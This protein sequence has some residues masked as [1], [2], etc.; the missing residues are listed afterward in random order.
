MPDPSSSEILPLPRQLGR[1]TLV[2]RL[3]Q[4]GMGVVYLARD[5]RLGRDVALKMIAGLT[6]DAAVKR[7]WREARVAASV[8]HPHVCQIFEVDET[9]SGLHIAME[10]LDGESLET[11]LERG[12]LKPRDAVRVATEVLGALGALHER[13]LVHRDVKPSNIFLTTHG[14][15]LLD[16]GLARPAL[17]DTVRLDAK[18]PTEVTQAGMILG[19]PRYMAPEQVSGET[20]DGR[21]DQYSL[22][23]VLFETL[24]GRPPFVGS[25]VFDLLYATLHERPPALQGPPAV[26][27]ID[28]V[29]RRSLEKDPA[30]RFATCE[31]MAVEL[32]AISLGESG[33][34]VASPVRALVRIIVPP[35]RML[36]ADP[37]ITFL[38]FGL[39]DAI[40]G[41]LAGLD[42]VVVRAT[43]VA[44][45]WAEEQPDPR[46]IAAE[47]DVDLVLLGS[48]LRV[49]EQMRA[50][51]QLVE[52]PS[53]TVVGST[54]VK[55]RLSDVF[56][57]EEE[58]TR[59][60]MVL[61]APRRSG[62]TSAPRRDVPATA[63]ALELY[64]RAME[65]S[66]SRD[67]LPEAR[68]L[69]EQV[70]QEDPA[71]APAWAN[72]GR[73]YRVIGKFNDGRDT[74][75][76]PAEEAFRRALALSPNLPVAH[77]FLTHF[78]AE[79]GRA[80][81]AIARLLEHA[82]ANRN[83]AN[84]FAG[85]VHACRYAGL[86]DASLAAHAEARR[87]DPTVATSLE[88][89]LLVLGEYEKFDELSL[90]TGPGDSG[91]YIFSLAVRNQRDKA[92][93]LLESG[94]LERLPRIYRM[95]AK[96]SLSVFDDDPAS[97][98]RK[99]EEAVAVFDDPE[100]IYFFGLHLVRVGALD[101][102]LEVIGQA[103]NGGF[104][105]AAALEKDPALAAVRGSSAFT[106]VL[107]AARRRQRTAQAIFE[108]G[109]GPILLGV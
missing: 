24:A 18:A 107:G 12:V 97:A 23:A 94:T 49:A 32:K 60:V 69:L 29:I 103:V 84:L 15:K 98:V 100:A 87:L 61:L 73:C 28:R 93:A 4:G 30:S 109:G 90:R 41:S 77:W 101:R 66:R 48:L 10:L 19:T 80:D 1:Y 91:A 46:R 104:S 31:R 70:V 36:K 40:S 39:A 5:D 54:N 67:Q 108:R 75:A 82:K 3:G 53:G 13:G 83:D 81:A 86:L 44:A 57:M 25:N 7:F 76:G 22:G 65:H 50:T 43:A 96:A 42:D 105:P 74:G 8:N 47:A 33:D 51:V 99:L 17:S 85:L 102:G 106:A 59:A 56:A 14:A 35:F 64:L 55:G 45:R 79:H 58:L 88:Y 37:D 26:V 92:L 95:S 89:T 71:F 21:A 16:F 11:R 78:E 38:S 20:L 72:L 68:S 34:Q 27:A 52:A 6:D 9:E 2:R 62:S 63:R